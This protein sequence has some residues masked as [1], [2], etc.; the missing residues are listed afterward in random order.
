MPGRQPAVAVAADSVDM[1]YTAAVAETDIPGEAHYYSRVDIVPAARF[2]TWVMSPACHEEGERSEGWRILE[3]S[4][5]SLMGRAL[6][7]H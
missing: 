2:D 1:D 6:A 5:H 7:F 3:S 4:L